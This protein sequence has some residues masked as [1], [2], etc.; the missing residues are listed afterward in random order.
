MES[1]GEY[2]FIIVGAGTAGCL[3]ADRLSAD[4]RSRVLLLEAGGRDRNPWIHI[5]VGYGRLFDDP[6]TNW[7]YESEPEPELNGRRLYQPRGKVLGGTSSI[8]GQL[9]TRGP[10]ADFDHWRRLG[11]EGWGYDD[12]LPYFRRMEDRQGTG[13]HYGRSGRLSVGDPPQRSE[14]ADAFLAAAAEAGHTTV[15]DFNGPSAEGAGYFQVTAR[16][17]RRCSAAVAYLRPALRR[18]NLR[19]LEHAE[20]VRIVLEG[21]RAVGIE[22]RRDRAAWHVTARGEVVLAGGVFNSPALLQRSGI[23]DAATLGRAGVPLLH[24]LPGVGENLQD[25]FM[26]SLVYRCTRPI[27]LNDD[28]NSLARRIAMGLRYALFRKGP[29]AANG[30]Y[31]GAYLRTDPNREVPNL[32]LNLAQWSVANNERARTKLHPFPGF[33]VGVINLRPQSR[34][35]VKIVTA[36]PAVAPEIRFGFFRAEEDRRIMLSGLTM[37]RHI[38]GMPALRAYVAAELSPGPDCRDEAQ[39]M[40]FLRDRGRSTLHPAGTCRMGVGADAVVDPR[41]RVHGLERLRVVDG[42]VMPLLVAANPMAA[43]YMIAEKGAGMI[44]AEARGSSG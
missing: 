2:D 9:Y 24:M 16:G 21:R 13:A 25:H 31:V 3:L 34:G 41:L 11:N 4:G 7:R 26:A 20:A 22:Y 5:P 8:N 14:L 32:Q 18:P 15:D 33:S 28:V 44:L 35:S 36:D 17:G 10:R 30:T 23:G 6:R 42:S 12:V 37:A 40:A 29:L 27:T 1:G 43:T 38:L 39:W 19:L